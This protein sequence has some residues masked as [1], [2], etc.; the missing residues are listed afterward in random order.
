[1][2]PQ[3]LAAGLVADPR[4]H[5]LLPEYR[6]IELYTKRKVLQFAE[7]QGEPDFMDWVAGVCGAFMALDAFLECEHFPGEAGPS[8]ERYLALPRGDQMGKLVAELY[9]ILRVA[10]AVAFHPHGHI[11][12]RK[13][14]PQIQRRDQPLGADA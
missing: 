11:R 13:R 9:R 2:L 5:L 3:D 10:R 4:N 14:R 8:W 12:G 6:Q 1:M 7:A